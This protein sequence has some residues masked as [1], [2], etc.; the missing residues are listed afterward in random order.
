MH[1]EAS[2][3]HHSGWS[4]CAW[5]GE[6]IERMMGDTLKTQAY[7]AFRCRVHTLAPIRRRPVTEQVERD[8]VFGLF[9]VGE[10]ARWST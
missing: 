8:P 10:L 5:R 2:S 9:I 3:I 7:G 1:F 6:A 4:L